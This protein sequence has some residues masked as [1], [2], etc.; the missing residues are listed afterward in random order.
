MGLEEEIVGVLREAGDMGATASQ[1]ARRIKRKREVISHY[2]WILKKAGRVTNR[3]RNVWVIQ[4]GLNP[5]SLSLGE[6]EKLSFDEYTH[7]AER[8]YELC[9]EK[10]KGAFRDHDV[11]HVVICN[12]EVVYKSDNIAG[13]VSHVIKDLM[14]KM[15][16][17]CYVFS[18]EDMV[19]EARWTRL[20]DDYYPTVELLLG[21]KGRTDEDVAG[22]GRKILTDFDTGNPYYIIFN[23][24]IGEDIV[25]SPFPYEI[26]RGIHLGEPYW[27]FLREIKI[28]VKDIQGAFRCKVVQARFVRLWEESPLLLA[29]PR[30]EGFVGRNLMINFNFKIT[31]NPLT[32]TSTVNY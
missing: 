14:M 20:N 30:R 26:H 31:L 3:S 8:A 19:E 17:P 22:E 18:R 25:P 9:K 10:V 12:G 2:L 6:F 7:M 5:F 16:G 11:H 15:G 1:I 32:H 23:E 28:C 24:K 27:Y 21:Q 4:K 29:N 13:V